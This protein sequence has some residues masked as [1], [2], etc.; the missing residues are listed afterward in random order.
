MWGIMQV[1]GWAVLIPWFIITMPADLYYE[2]HP[3][4]PALTPFFTN[5]FIDWRKGSLLLLSTLFLIVS[6]GI[7]HTGWQRMHPEGKIPKPIQRN[8]KKFA[9]GF[10]KDEFLRS[11]RQD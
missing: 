1:V 10:D 8:R 9:R 3:I 2:T 4:P 11:L 5:N 6:I 7:I